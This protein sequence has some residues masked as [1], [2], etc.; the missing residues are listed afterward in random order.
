MPLT[1]IIN[2]RKHIIWDWNGTILNDVEYALDTVNWLLEKYCIPTIS[3][4]RYREIFDF[5]VKQYYDRLGFDY[6]ICSFESLCDQFVD[7]FM[8]NFSDCKP[9][10]HIHSLLKESRQLCECQ[11]IL[12]ATDQKSLD[13]MIE[14]FDFK[15]LFDHVF[16]TENRMATSKIQRGAELVEGSGIDPAETLLVGDTLH[17]AEVA[18]ELGIDVLLVTHGHHSKEK[19]NREIGQKTQKINVSMFHQGQVTTL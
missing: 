3:Y 5:P 18:S 9:F 17:D 4:D 13:D 19:L 15:H 14:H 11:S 6:S 12:S 10:P 7:R 16:G 8:K 2:S 1:E